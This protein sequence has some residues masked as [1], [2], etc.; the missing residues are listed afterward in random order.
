MQFT[1]EESEENRTILP[2]RLEEAVLF[3]VA[4]ATKPLGWDDGLG[5]AEQS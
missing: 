4:E 2:E 3:T 5:R 1:A